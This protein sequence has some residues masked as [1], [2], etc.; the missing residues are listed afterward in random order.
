MMNPEAQVAKSGEK[1]R[2]HTPDGVHDLVGN[3]EEWVWDDWKGLPG[4]LEGGAWYTF[5]QLQLLSYSRPVIVSVLIEEFFCWLSLLLVSIRPRTRAQITRCTAKTRRGKEKS[6]FCIQPQMSSPS[7]KRRLSIN[8]NTPISPMSYPRVLLVQHKLHLYV[9]NTGYHGTRMGNRVWK[10]SIPLWRS[11]H[12][13]CLCCSLGNVEPSGRF[14]V[15][16][17]SGAMDMV[18]NLWEWTSS[19]APALGSKP[20]RDRG[21]S[22][23]VDHR[24]STC[25]VSMVILRPMLIKHFD[26]IRC[27]EDLFFKAA[28]SPVKCPTDMVSGSS[29]CIDFKYPKKGLTRV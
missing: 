10:Q 9:R 3:L 17:P 12:S 23:F 5:S 26:E 8:L 19:D 7:Q 24:K 1:E 22:W 2:C 27:V 14:L 15:P 28:Q 18:G 20:L 25:Q 13:I 29:F 4:G 6:G 21:G 16:I 11:I